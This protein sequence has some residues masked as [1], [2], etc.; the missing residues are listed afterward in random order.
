[1]SRI[2]LAAAV[3]VTITGCTARRFATITP[4]MTEAQ[5]MTAMKSAPDEV[6]RFDERY[7][8]WFYG[9][10]RCLLMEQG[11]VVGKEVSSEDRFPT[12]GGG[13]V[14]I[15][16]APVCAPPGVQKEREHTVTIN[17]GRG[18]GRFTVPTR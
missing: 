4:G 9:D 10:D 18:F 12:P 2:A 6:K 7:A 16:H 1:M 3:F 15:E 17:S 5:V 14:S 8:A 11:A 13:M